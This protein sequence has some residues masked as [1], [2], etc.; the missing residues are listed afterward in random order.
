[1]DSIPPEIERQM[2]I[3]PV[4]PLPQVKGRL[5]LEQIKQF[6]PADQILV[7]G[8]DENNQICIAIYNTLAMTVEQARR[9]EA[10]MVSRINT[11][12]TGSLWFAGVVV[13]AVIS[14]LAMKYIHA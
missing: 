7:S 8:L 13:V 6:S 4:P 11:I 5:T 12:R 14:A 9:S 2:E 3:K 1:M 10:K